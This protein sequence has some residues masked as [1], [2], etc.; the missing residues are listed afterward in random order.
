MSDEADNAQEC[1]ERDIEN[2][3][4]KPR[5][6]GPQATGHCLNCDT[7]VAVGVR[8]CDH[9]CMSDWSK[10]RALNLYS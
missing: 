2:A 9:D 4:R 1:I 3:L 6:Q 7:P 5:E 8:W 10:R